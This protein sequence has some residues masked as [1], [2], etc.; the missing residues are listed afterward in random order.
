MDNPRT[1]AARDHDDSDLIEGMEDAPSHK[2]AQGGN[3]Q[4]DIATRAEQQK[5]VDG[6]PGV[7]RVGDK[8]K[9]EEADLPRF[10]E[11]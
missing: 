5:D 7:T 3:L 9:P 2:G 4:R 6:A 1:Q 8:D 11:R 10:N